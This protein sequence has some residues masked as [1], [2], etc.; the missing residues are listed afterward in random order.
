VEGFV[1]E[2]APRVGIRAVTATGV[3]ILNNTVRRSGLTGILTGYT[4]SVEISGNSA[5]GSFQQHGIYVSNSTSSADNPIIRGN[6]CFDNEQNGIQLNGDCDVGGDGVISGA[7][8]DGNT[9]H[10]NNWKGFSLI[11]VQNSVIQNNL[12][13]ENGLLAGAGGVH[14]ADQPGCGKPSNDNV[15]VNNTI[16][17]PRITGIRMSN[18]STRNTIFNNLEIA[19]N[20]SRTIVDEANGNFIDA[21]SNL[22]LTSL[23]GLFVAP[24]SGNYHL[25]SGSAALNRAVL[26]YHGAGLPAED[27]DGTNRP[28]GPL[29]DIGADEVAVATGVGDAPALAVQ[30]EQ[31]VPNPF[32]PSTRIV[33]VVP[34]G[35]EVRVT[36]DVFDVNGRRI[37]RLASE[38]PSTGRVAIEWDGRDD[39]GRAMASGVYF[40]RLVAGATTITRRM[41]LLK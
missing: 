39:A 28:Q 30:L 17:E 24:G 10:H 37:R 36:L 20:P 41:T 26:S 4:P 34:T 31:N 7:L 23:T 2:D 27:I 33:Y 5:S 12:I 9:I 13:Y 29:P 11:S 6:E 3:R 16:H 22:R 25:A 21:V 8:L 38:R 35:G 15:I 1:V 32:N 18:G 40:Y 14:L 19:S